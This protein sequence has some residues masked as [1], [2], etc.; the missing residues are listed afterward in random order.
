MFFCFSQHGVCEPSPFCPDLTSCQ[1]SSF[2]EIKT[3]FT[4]VLSYAWRWNIK[5]YQTCS[6]IHLCGKNHVWL[7]S[8]YD[9]LF[10][11]FPLALLQLPCIITCIFDCHLIFLISSFPFQQKRWQSHVFLPGWQKGHTTRGKKKTRED[12]SNEFKK[13]DVRI[14]ILIQS[15]QNLGIIWTPYIFHYIY[16]ILIQT[17]PSII[18]SN[19]RKR[20]CMD[21]TARCIIGTLWALS[22]C[23]AGEVLPC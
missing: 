16:N 17:K 18:R 4:V 20:G 23:A 12:R 13:I 1:V 15:K 9:V 6:S 10:V 8:F 21:T 7:T 14:R 11:C 2:G 19:K 5:I 22:P 3:L